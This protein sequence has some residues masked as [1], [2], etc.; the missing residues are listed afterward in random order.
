MYPIPYKV[1]GATMKKVRFKLTFPG[2]LEI[3]TVVILGRELDPQSISMQDV[4]DKVIETE[5]YIEKITG[6]HVHIEQVA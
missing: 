6:R 2:T 5:Q 3:P 4:T 1:I